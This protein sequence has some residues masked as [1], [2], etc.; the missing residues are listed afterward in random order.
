[1]DD[2]D[3][4]MDINARGMMLCVRAVSKVMLEQGI[5][6]VKGRNSTLDIA[7]GSIVNIGSGNSY[8]PLP[9]KAAYVASKHAMMGI[10]SVAGKSS[11]PL[12]EGT[13]LTHIVP[14]QP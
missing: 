10:T 3:R 13:N 7:R 12:F 11:K 2:F 1:M 14:T 6:T 4:V 8:C 5:K 9:G